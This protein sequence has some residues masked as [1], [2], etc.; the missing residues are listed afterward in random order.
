MT[1]A[2]VILIPGLI[3]WLYKTTILA[4]QHQRFVISD[5]G[6]LIVVTWNRMCYQLFKTAIDADIPTGVLTTVILILSATTKRSGTRL[7]LL[8]DDTGGHFAS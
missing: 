1:V 6:P 5:L 4:N 7:K 2:Y 8:K 3:W